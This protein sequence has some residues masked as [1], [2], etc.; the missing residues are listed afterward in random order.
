M[1]FL[2]RKKGVLTVLAYRETELIHSHNCGRGKKK[3]SPEL[4]QTDSL[5]CNENRLAKGR[6]KGLLSMSFQLQFEDD[7]KLLWFLQKYKVILFLI[8]TKFHAFVKKKIPKPND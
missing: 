2:S 6:G 7:T 1:P 5:L 8:R 3:K 4:L